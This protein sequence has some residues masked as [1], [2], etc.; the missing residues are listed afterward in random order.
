MHSEFSVGFKMETVWQRKSAYITASR[1]YR[2]GLRTREEE[3][4]AKTSS[5]KLHPQWPTSSNQA[6]LPNSTLSYKFIKRLNLLVGWYPI[7]QSSTSPMSEHIE[8]LGTF[9]V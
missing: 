4:G 9:L 3:A 5:A 7:I 6:P 2:V 8:L 1:K